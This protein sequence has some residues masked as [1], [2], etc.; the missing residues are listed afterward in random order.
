[1]ETAVNPSVATSNDGAI[2]SE[3]FA[4]ETA[5]IKVGIPSRRDPRT[6]L[7]I[8]RVI[9]ILRRIS[10]VTNQGESY[11]RVIDLSLKRGPLFGR[12]VGFGVNGLVSLVD[13]FNLF[14]ALFDR[15]H[16]EGPAQAV[17]Q[18]K[19]GLQVPAITEIYVVI[20][21]RTLV[22]RRRERRIQS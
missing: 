7:A 17:S 3:Y 10:S 9:G 5:S 15:R 20:W 6:E 1:M 13:K 22:E 21:N 8:E 16:F 19:G 12:Q 14:P 4:H 2:L 11:D 18:S